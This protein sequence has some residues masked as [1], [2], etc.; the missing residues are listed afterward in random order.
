MFEVYNFIHG[1]IVLTVNEIPMGVVDVKT[2]PIHF[3]AQ[4]SEPFS[5]A[6]SPIP[7]SRG[8]TNEGN[9]INLATGTFTAPVDGTYHF[10]FSGVK[11]PSSP[12]PLIVALRKGSLESLTVGKAYT[13]GLNNQLSLS[14]QATVKLVKD[15]KIRLVLEN[16]TLYDTFDN[17]FSHF[18]G[19]LLEEDLNVPLC[20]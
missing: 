9:A 3:Y 16:G 11:D 19:S 12:N 6:N 10:T 1:L 5:V 20:C 8:Y 15:D 7:F 17:H 2:S 4:R 14:L 13:D 18:T